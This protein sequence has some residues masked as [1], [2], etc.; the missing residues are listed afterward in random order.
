MNSSK[1]QKTNKPLITEANNIHPL[2]PVD[3]TPRRGRPIGSTKLA[4]VAK[5]ANQRQIFG[6][7]PK[8]ATSI[9][10]S[11]PLE[12]TPGISGKRKAG[13]LITP[14]SDTAAKTAQTVSTSKPPATKQSVPPHRQ[15]Q[16]QRRKAKFLSDKFGKIPVEERTAEQKRALAWAA[17]VMGEG[18]QPETGKPTQPKRIQPPKYRP[19]TGAAKYSD[20]ARAGL[21]M[22]VMDNGHPDGSISPDNWRKLLGAVQKR[23]LAIIKSHPGT[24]P[25]C[26][27]AGWY[28]GRLKLM[29]FADQRSIDLFGMA[30]TQI[31]EIWPGAKIQLIGKNDIPTRP[32]GRIKVPE[33][34]SN[35]QEILEMAK[36]SNPQLPTD[37]WRVIKVEEAKE[38]YRHVTLLITEESAKQIAAG[39][40]R[41]A[42]GFITIP[43]WTYKPK[44]TNA[45]EAK[46]A[47]HPNTDDIPSSSNVKES[48]TPTRPMET[49][50]AC[51][52]KLAEPLLDMSMEEEESLLASDD[53]TNI[54]VI[55]SCPEGVADQPASL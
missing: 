5:K 30:I 36:V 8:S 6:T 33:E 19:E 25:G 35:E 7:L 4:T 18:R 1:K 15:R 40:N 21:V 31:G 34:L 32:R 41:I 52:M 23:F 27:D 2:T 51:D 45:E 37:E 17:N 39:N 42:F 11:R 46:A 48:E 3:S 24:P 49:A 38:G 47:D 26:T 54:T 29:A 44:T 13:E 10:P 22:A 12:L 55:E 16:R 28:Q 50:S 9:P 53:D 43:I 20:A 14:P